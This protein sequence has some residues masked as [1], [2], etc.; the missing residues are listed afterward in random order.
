MKNTGVTYTNRS[1]SRELGGLFSVVTKE[2]QKLGRDL[3]L[4]KEGGASPCHAL[5]AEFYSNGRYLHELVF[6]VD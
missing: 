6:I 2:A 5:A 3:T 4:I 1:E